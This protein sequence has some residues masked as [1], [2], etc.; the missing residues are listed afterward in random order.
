M[1]N[2][3]LKAAIKFI[4]YKEKQDYIETEEYYHIF[5]YHGDAIK[6]ALI[7]LSQLKDGTHPDM[8]MVKRGSCIEA[9]EDAFRSVYGIPISAAF[10]QHDNTVI[11]NAFIQGWKN[12]ML[13]AAQ[14][15][16]MK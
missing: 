7:E 16:G 12:A 10:R 11:A 13:S 14:K 5:K 1:T 9:M 4:A 8:V 2:E 3:E 15:E 6:G